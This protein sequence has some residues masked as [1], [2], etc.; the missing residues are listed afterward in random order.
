MYI[1]HLAFVCPP[2]V[3]FVGFYCDRSFVQEK[4]WW[5]RLQPH[6][7]VRRGR[8]ETTRPGGE[9]GRDVTALA[10]SLHYT[11]MTGVSCSSELCGRIALLLE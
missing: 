5:V 9:R 7:S 4:E 1:I 8:E 10:H 6:I 3:S 2:D 11:F